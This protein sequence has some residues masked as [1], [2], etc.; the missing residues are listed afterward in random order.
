METAA[1][2]HLNART[3]PTPAHLSPAARAFL[4]LAAA[5]PPTP[6]P[7]GT[8]QQEWDAA[9]TAW[10]DRILPNMEAILAQIPMALDTQ[11]I[12]HCQ[13]HIA[14]PPGLPPA[15]EN[16]AFIDIHGGG[17]VFGAGRFAQ[18]MAIFRAAALGVR[19][20]SIDYRVPARA[21]LS[22]RAG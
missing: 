1:P 18:A 12:A 17:L 7:A 6:E 20:I 21:P 11:T 3:I 9:A 22:R 10:N 14:T 13:I 4:D 8:S 19:V 2:L 5:A 16:Y 15:R